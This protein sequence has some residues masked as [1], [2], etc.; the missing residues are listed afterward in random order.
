MRLQGIKLH[1]WRRFGH[2]E[3]DFDEHL[4]VITGTNNSGKSSVLEALN[5][6]LTPPQIP[7]IHT[8]EAAAQRFA[9]RPEAALGEATTVGEV[10]YSSG[11][12]VE[13]CTPVSSPHDVPAPRSTT[14]TPG[15]LINAD[16]EW[17]PEDGHPI[18]Q[19]AVDRLYSAAAARVARRDVRRGALRART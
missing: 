18:Y 7:V 4:T 9:R 19:R 15:I 6:V 10:R 5:A 11:T 16:R 12:T 3:L 17:P 2:L 13:L 8:A 14:A 1:G